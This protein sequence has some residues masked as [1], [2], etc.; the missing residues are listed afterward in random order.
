M[1]KLKKWLYGMR[2]AANSWE[3]FLHREACG[4]GFPGRVFLPSGFLQ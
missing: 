2:K 3:E 4:E 1:V